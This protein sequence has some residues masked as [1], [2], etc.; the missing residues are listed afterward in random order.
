MKKYIPY[1]VTLIALAI[2]IVA[3]WYIRRCHE[4]DTTN[5][6]TKRD[7]IKVKVTESYGRPQ[8]HGKTF[9]LDIPKFDIP[10]Y[11]LIQVDSTKI[12]FRDSIKYVVLPS[13]S[14]HTKVGGIDIYHHGV[15]SVIDS[16]NVEYYRSHIREQLKP[17]EWKHTISVYGSA[18]YHG[19]LRLPVGAQY[20]YHPARWFGVGGK[21]EHDFMTKQTGVYATANFTFGW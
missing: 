12:E 4:N 18:G 21:V 9:K 15:R 10:K 19:G 2:G 6:V 17:K 5:V 14:Y 8:I 3:G 13:E 1:I 11:Y 7:T 20:L 16:V